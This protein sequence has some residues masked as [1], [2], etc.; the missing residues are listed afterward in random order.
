MVIMTQW[1][2][3]FG[4]GSADGDASM[5]NLLGGKGANLAEMSSLGLPVPPGF[6]ITTEACVHYYAQGETYPADLA[7]QVAAGLQKVEGITGKRFGD[8]ANPLLVSVRSGARASMPGMM[9]TV[10]NLG[11]NDQ[12]VEGL[13][14]LSGD[15]RFAFDSY[16]RFITMYS[17]VVLGLGHDLFEEVLDDHKDRLGVTV[18]TDLSAGDW[19]KVVG[20]YKAVVERELGEGFPQ[21]PNDQLWGAVGA[22]FASWM[23]DRAKFY[24]RM[25]DIP[26]SWGTAVNVQSMVFGNMGQTSAT[27]VAF[28]R[29]PST[30]EARLYGEF[31]INAQGEDVV[32]GIRT[33]QSLTRAGREEMGETAPSME[34]AMPEVFGQFVEVVGRLESHY[35]DMQDIEFTVEQGRLWMLQTR[36]GK[37]TAK[38][39]LKIA[40]DLAAEGVISQEE[41]V[42]RVEPAALDQLLHPT[43]DPKAPRNVVTTGLPASPG[44]ATGK[45]VFDADE[46]ERMSQLGDAV[47]LVRT[48]TS[49]ED[50]HGMHAARGIVTARGGMTSHAAVVAR[51]MGRP[52]VSGA[53]DI[54]IDD[55]ARTFT[56]KGRTFKAGDIITIDGSKGEVIDGAVPMIEPELTGDFQTLM[57]WADGIRRLKVRANAETPTDAKTARGFGAEGVGLCRT[58]HMFFDDTRIAAVREMILADDE[59]GRRAALA[60]IAPFQKADFVE[61]FQIMAGLPVTIRLLDPPLH[62]FIP[63]TEAEMDALAASQGLDA[64]KLKRRAADLHETN[65]M[66]GHRGCRLGVAYPEIYEMQVRAII[67]AALEVKAK[68]GQ[69]PIPEI[70]HP[71]VA[72]GGEMNFLRALT[73]RTAQAVFADTGDQV[74]YM[75]GTMIELPRAALRAADLAQSAEFFS[76]GTNDLTQTTF[77]ISRDDSGR[78]LQAYLDKGIFETDPFVRLDRDGVGDLIRIAAERGRAARPGIKLGICGEHGG[79]PSSIA[80]CESVGL[81][82]VSCSPYRVPIARLAAAQAALAARTGKEREKDR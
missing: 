40:V 4:G 39:A 27:G 46:A 70:M 21:D 72:L 60:K 16:R 77:G 47:I 52:C 62:E 33:P 28:T 48:E 78:F 67:E 75:V 7:E 80:F 34:E 73:D 1:V 76:F 3:G 81:D 68:S 17:N 56:V 22:V 82:Y 53:G 31:L 5:K 61:L 2:Y 66:L 43:L 23:N 58:E 79:D 65:P 6:T 11:L 74:D 8:P 26:E 54:Q 15:R 44:A 24:R 42:S 9:D 45:I 36:N 13:A 51:G 50:I 18:D 20:D 37:R 69:A 14:A 64:A 41:A 19:E 59:A 63:H 32:A 10:L 29:N 30:G 25:H 38:S 71:L 57:G 12:T 35:R 55:K 49:P